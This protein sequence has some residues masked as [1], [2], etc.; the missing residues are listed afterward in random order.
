MN[1]NQAAFLTIPIDPNG[2]IPNISKAPF[3]LYT[4]CPT[5]GPGISQEHYQLEVVAE[6]VAVY[7]PAR[8]EVVH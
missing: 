6:G 2:V 1:D 4:P 7:R 3:D 8:N 5:F